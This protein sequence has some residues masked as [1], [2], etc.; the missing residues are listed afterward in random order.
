MKLV[1]YLGPA[2]RMRLGDVVLLRGGPPAH[3]SDAAYEGLGTKRAR[4]AI[5]QPA[6][7]KRRRRRRSTAQK[8]I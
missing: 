6:P 5:V 8:E 2:D 1:R 7:V 4:L 3:I